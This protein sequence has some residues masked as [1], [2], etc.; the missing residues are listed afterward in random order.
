MSAVPGLGKLDG[1]GRLQQDAVGLLLNVVDKDLGR[2]H[3]PGLGSVESTQG[4]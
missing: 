2:R 1:A 3:T 4:H